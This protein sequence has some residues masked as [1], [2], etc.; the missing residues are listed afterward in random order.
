MPTTND[1]ADHVRPPSPDRTSRYWSSKTSPGSHRLSFC[2]FSNA[3]NTVPSGATVGTENWFSSH[4]PAGPVSWKVQS[5]GF[6]PEISWGADQLKPPS[7]LW[8]SKIGEAAEAAL[9][10]SKSVQ[11]RYVLPKN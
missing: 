1:G 4:S 2:S 8:D 7:S 6:E 5:P 9:W 10:D 3:T 11:G